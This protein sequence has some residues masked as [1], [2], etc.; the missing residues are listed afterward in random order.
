MIPENCCFDRFAWIW[1]FS[2]S[3]CIEIQVLPPG[4]LGNCLSW[5]MLRCFFCWG[6][7]TWFFIILEA[8][9]TPSTKE[10][11]PSFLPWKINVLR[12]YW[13]VKGWWVFEGWC[14]IQN[15]HLLQVLLWGLHF[16]KISVFQIKKIQKVHFFSNFS[17][18]CCF[19]FFP[20]K[21]NMEQLF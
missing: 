13:K 16:G 4:N 8:G 17:K 21:K 15:P 14:S 7:G 9:E 1:W 3:K 20:P 11:G 19:E 10:S 12:H 6:H 18:A 2:T 5:V